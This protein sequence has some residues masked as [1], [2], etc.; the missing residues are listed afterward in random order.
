MFTLLKSQLTR[1]VNDLTLFFLCRKAGRLEIWLWE[2]VKVRSLGKAFSRP[3][4]LVRTLRSTRSSSSLKQN[5]NNNNMSYW[6]KLN[7]RGYFPK[8]K[9]AAVPKLV[10]EMED[11]LK[12]NTMKPVEVVHN[13]W[14]FVY[15]KTNI[16]NLCCTG[17]L[18][19]SSGI[20]FR[21]FSISCIWIFIR[22]YSKKRVFS[23]K[24][25][26]MKWDQCLLLCSQQFQRKCCLKPVYNRFSYIVSVSLRTIVPHKAFIS[27]RLSVEFK[28]C[29]DSMSTIV[30]CCSWFNH[31]LNYLPV[32][33]SVDCK[34]NDGNYCSCFFFLI[35]LQMS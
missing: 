34:T 4:K 2:A 24:E 25:T 15:R 14:Q 12:G 16:R 23:S 5:K 33:L 26:I 30:E 19:K 13:M 22:P 9:S 21:S 10:W 7:L 8:L 27:I 6:R 11:V 28:V 18:I 1:W 3:G 17:Q 20:R 35:F 29:Y 31:I 32:W